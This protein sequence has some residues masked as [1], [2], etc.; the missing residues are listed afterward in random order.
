MCE[1]ENHTLYSAEIVRVVAPRVGC[2]ATKHAALAVLHYKHTIG[3]FAAE[4]QK[5]METG[6]IVFKTVYSV[7]VCATAQ[8]MIE[9]AMMLALVAFRQRY[10]LQLLAQATV[11]SSDRILTQNF[12]GPI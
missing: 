7:P 11:D 6:T 10:S 12:A 9:V 3:V 8:E 2:D 5:S 4:V 1:F